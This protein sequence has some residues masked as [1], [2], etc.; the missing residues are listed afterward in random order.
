MTNREQ[1]IETAE[2]KFLRS[3]S[4]RK[5]RIGEELNIFKRK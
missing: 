1:N 5:T 4:V 3:K 2:M